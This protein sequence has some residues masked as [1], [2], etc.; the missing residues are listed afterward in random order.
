MQATATC[1]FNKTSISLT[2]PEIFSVKYNLESPKS[3]FSQ[4][5]KK[6]SALPIQR[7]RKSASNG[8]IT[9]VDRRSKGENL[10]SPLDEK[11]HELLPGGRRAYLDEQD[12][13]TLLDPPKE[14]IPLDPASYNPA[15]Y[16]WKKIG[17]I[18]EE[19]RHRLL[20][21][22]KPRLVSRIWEIA[23]TRYEDSKLVKKSASSLLS[24]GDSLLS[25][26]IWSCR[27]SGGP[28]PV[29]WIRDFKKAIFCG[30]D[31]K[32]YGRIFLG[33][34]LLPRITNSICPLYFTVVKLTEVMS[35][36]Q[37][38][39]L[40]YEFGDGLLDLHEY[41]E[42]FPKPAKHPW[43]FDDYVVV[44]IRHV[45]PGVM[46]GQAWQEGKALE[47]VPRKFCGEILMVKDYAV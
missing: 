27:T 15:A 17:D 46:A 45:G 39:D 35:T 23:G 11:P 1:I 47:Q 42:G 24:T 7:F 22:L 10:S 31:G 2:N 9:A 3:R 33:G 37:P 34:S 26:E 44:Y 19:R 5:V 14:L 13:V 16:L 40:A 30:K 41:P 28:V 12:I 20:Y 4:Q 25:P 6:F 36:E 32:T 21:L 8:E 29:A 43:P 38:C 18:P